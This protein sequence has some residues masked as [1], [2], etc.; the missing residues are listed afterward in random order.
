MS[1]RFIEL[2]SNTLINLE[3]LVSVQWGEDVED[4]SDDFVLSLT[5]SNDEKFN[6][7]YEDEDHCEG[8][9]QKIKRLLNCE[10]SFQIVPS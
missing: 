7:F 1:D 9:Y 10:T 5:L 2:M 4:N 8:D 6:F 3:H